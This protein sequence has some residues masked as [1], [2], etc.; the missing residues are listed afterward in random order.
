MSKSFKYDIAVIG[1]G[2]AGSSAAYS[3]AKA[4]AKVALIEKFKLPRHKLCGGGFDEW[5]RQFADIP[6]D[7][8]QRT[9]TKSV[10]IVRETPLS[11]GTL[12]M[13]LKV[14][15]ARR[16]DLDNAL[17]QKAVKAGAALMEGKRAVAPI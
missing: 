2:P 11:L 14:H 16:E 6:M 13:E 10:P 3:A 9:A 12:P 1:A 4:G 15:L 7:I 17:A 8:I 5:T